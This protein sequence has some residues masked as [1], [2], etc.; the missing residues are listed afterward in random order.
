MLEYRQWTQ[1]AGRGA[2]GLRLRGLCLS[3]WFRAR[4]VVARG[5]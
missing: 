4:W 3:C 5:V 1:G 2:L